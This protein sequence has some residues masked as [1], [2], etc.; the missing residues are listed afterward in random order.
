[1]LNTAQRQ[2]VFSLN[3]SQLTGTLLAFFLQK[4]NFTKNRAV[5]L[6]GYSLGGSVTFN[7]L[8][9][10]KRMNEYDDN[11][12]GQILND[13]NLWACCYVIDVSKTYDEILEK[14]QYATVANGNFN[15]C[16]SRKDMILSKVFT[17]VYKGHKAVGLQ[18]IFENIKNEEDVKVSK[19]AINYNVTDISPGHG[20]YAP[21]C[22]KFMPLVKDAY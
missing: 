1:M 3:Q 16:Y 20:D 6:V 12:A 14:A 11:R 8:K 15:N 21:N 2:F 7:C 4:S 22:G 17:Y 13:V 5:T 9:I 18:P 19:L 10:L